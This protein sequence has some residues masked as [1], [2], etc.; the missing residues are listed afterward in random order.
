MDAAGFPSLD[1][2]FGDKF[3]TARSILD[4]FALHPAGEH[5]RLTSLTGRIASYNL[6]VS[7]G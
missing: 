6:R 2:G 5:V 7:I 3:V 1:Q 4:H